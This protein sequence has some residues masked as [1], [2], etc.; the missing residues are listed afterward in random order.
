MTH[1]MF[2]SLFGFLSHVT[3]FKHADQPKVSQEDS[4]N[5]LDHK[6]ETFSLGNVADLCSYTHVIQAG[7]AKLWR[8]GHLVCTASQCSCRL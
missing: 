2:Q 6:V 5:V 3:R 7:A 8:T 4:N 1:T